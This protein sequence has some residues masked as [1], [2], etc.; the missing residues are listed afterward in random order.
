MISNN[1]ADYGSADEWLSALKQDGLWLSQLQQLQN[2]SPD[3]A[4]TLRDIAN[5]KIGRGETYGFWDSYNHQVEPVVREVWDMADLTL[6]KLKIQ[7]IGMLS[8]EWLEQHSEKDVTNNTKKTSTKKKPVKPEKPRE[9]MT[10]KRKSACI[11]LPCP[12][13]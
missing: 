12:V 1:R 7:A 11:V 2:S 10:F 3:A 6:P 9:T 8:M 5:E 13:V 4:S